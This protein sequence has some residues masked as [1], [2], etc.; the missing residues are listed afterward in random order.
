MDANNAVSIADSIADYDALHAGPELFAGVVDDADTPLTDESST[1]H[2]EIQNQRENVDAR[3]NPA[4]PLSP[5]QGDSTSDSKGNDGDDSDGVEVG[6][7]PDQ[8]ATNNLELAEASVV[9]HN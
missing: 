5:F 7:D 9:S 8:A 4:V 2:A 3:G 1:A 6:S